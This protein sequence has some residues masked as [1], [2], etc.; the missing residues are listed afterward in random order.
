MPD[1][2]SRSS[3]ARLLSARSAC[4]AASSGCRPRPAMKLPSSD[5]PVWPRTNS[6]VSLAA[7]IA[8]CQAMSWPNQSFISNVRRR[9]TGEPITASASICTI[10]SGSGSPATSRPVP[11]GN[12]SRKRLPIASYTGLRCARS[13]SDVVSLVMSRSDPPAACNAAAML[14]SA[15]WVCAAAS[16]SAGHRTIGLQ[17]APSAQEHP[18]TAAD[19]AGDGRRIERCGSLA[20][21]AGTTQRQSHPS[22][23]GH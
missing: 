1:P 16:P 19:S 12:T 9:W 3:V 8:P 11:T 2:A 6:S 14:S 4:A 7:I 17:C 13:T 5:A 22:A 20:A 10:S 23:A 15:A 18:R 21:G